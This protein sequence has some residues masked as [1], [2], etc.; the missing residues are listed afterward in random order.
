MKVK[1]LIASGLAA[2]LVFVS[3]P[4]AALADD[5][6]DPTPPADT[7]APIVTI[8]SPASGYGHDLLTVTVESSDD[9]GVVNTE[10]Y[11]DGNLIGSNAGP[12][13]SFSFD[14]H[15]GS[16]TL[17]AKAYDAAGNVGTSSPVTI[18]GTAGPQPKWAYDDPTQAWVATDQ[19]S[20]SWNGATGY[21]ISPLYSYDTQ[22]GWYHVIHQ[23]PPAPAPAAGSGSTGSGNA[24]SANDPASLL[25]SL[26]GLT[27]PSNSNTGAGSNNN[28]NLNNT[29]TA[30]LQNLAQALVN[31]NIGSTATSGDA[32]ISNSTDAGD[33]TSGNAQVLT[34]LLSLLNSMWSWAS[35][36]LTT[37]VKNIFGD[38]TGDITLQPGSVSGGG[39]QLG[40]LPSGGSASNSNTGADS[41]NQAGVSNTNDLTLVNRPDGTINNNLDLLAQSGNASIDKSTGAGDATTGDALVELNL[42]NM[43]NSA[44]SAGQSFFGLLNIFGNLN[45]DILFPQGFLN[46][47]VGDSST[48]GGGTSVA[49]NS[50]TGADSNNSAG[51][52]NNNNLTAVNSPSAL[53]NNNIQTAAQSGN[54]A[55]TDSTGAG[56][57]TTGN[58]DTSTNLYNLFNTS[59]FGDNAVLVLVN[60]LGHWV[61]GI[62]NLPGGGQSGGA[63]LTGNASVSN[64]N[65]GANSNNDASANTQN[66]VNLVNAPTG[67]IN[68]NINAG[69]LS[70]NA[71]VSDSTGAGGATSG[72]ATVATNVA[73]IFGSALNLKKWF[74]VLV[75]NV[76]GDWFGSVAQDTAAGNAP[77]VNSNTGTGQ[78]G[79]KTVTHQASQPTSAG[80]ANGQAGNSNQAKTNVAQGGS[81]QTLLASAHTQLVQQQKGAASHNNLQL[82]I[83][84]VAGLML[85]ASGALFRADKRAR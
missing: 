37:F 73:N 84:L 47:A 61:G 3:T 51:V 20:F 12:G 35:G 34:N 82:I 18:T 50:N 41:T 75:I 30:L 70:G 39:G 29:N 38:H 81:N 48:G 78:G 62:M 22:S 21:W 57:A 4:F 32:S 2:L 26:L 68:N 16:H 74:G 11:A 45:G 42:L 79:V 55:V 7:Q 15:L 64:N 72:N 1:R 5:P 6:V 10:A 28:A 71:T 40:S 36:G 24:G 67:T 14:P 76:F 23:A 60:V 17:L 27:D 52:T 46:G 19:P 65:T 77:Q 59:L 69:A 83:F 31:N 54:A 85:A 8:T 80:A 43:I 49:S 13:G 9:V 56:G 25:A 44:I 33:A 53:F 58:A 66:N 63:L